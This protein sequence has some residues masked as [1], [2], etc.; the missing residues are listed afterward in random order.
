[1]TDIYGA[2]L[3]SRYLAQ[4]QA[5]AAPSQ[6]V[7]QGLGHPVKAGDHLLSSAAECRS[8]L[9]GL[10]GSGRVTPNP[11]PQGQGLCVPGT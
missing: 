5:V 9:V 1:M 6:V 10:R 4:Q 7:A 3:Y 2:N 8:I 11:S